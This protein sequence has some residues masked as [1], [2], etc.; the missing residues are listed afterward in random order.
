MFQEQD[1]SVDFMFHFQGDLPL[2]FKTIVS[3]S[4]KPFFSLASL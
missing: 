4:Y 3:S 1:F 2:E